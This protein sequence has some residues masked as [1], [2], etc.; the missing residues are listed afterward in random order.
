MGKLSFYARKRIVNLHLLGINISQ[1]VRK[2]TEEDGI[3][4]SRPAVSL[5]LSRFK[6]TGSLYDRARK[7]RNPKL[8]TRHFDVIDEEMK[9]NDELS[10]VDLQRILLARCNITVSARTIRRVRRKL[11][12]MRSGTKYCQLIKD[13]NKPKCM[14]HCLKILADGDDLSDVIFSDECSVKIERCTRRCFHKVGEPRRTK[15]Q[16][17][18]PLKVG[19]TVC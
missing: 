5:S 19:F 8:V 18:H 15:G 7:G 4:A 1:I 3:I 14:E 6:R 9:K 13:V 10:S 12:W 17:K 16:P 2:L 11:G